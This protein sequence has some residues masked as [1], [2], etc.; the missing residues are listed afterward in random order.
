M[1]SISAE[2]NQ[3]VGYVLEQIRS[4]ELK[5]LASTNSGWF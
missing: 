5:W 4:T 3:N 1:E 2:G